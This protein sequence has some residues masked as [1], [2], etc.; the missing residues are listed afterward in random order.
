MSP[1]SSRGIQP[2]AA[3]SGY[4]KPNELRAV[5]RPARQRHHEAAWRIGNGASERKLRAMPSGA[6][7]ALRVRARSAA[8]G[9]HGLPCAS[10]LDQQQAACATRRQPVP[11][12]PCAD[13]R[14]RQ[15]HVHW[16]GGSLRLLA[17]GRLLERRLPRGDPRLEHQPEDVLLRTKEPMNSVATIGCGLL[18][19]VFIL[20]VQPQLHGAEVSAAKLPPPA[21]VTVDFG[22]D[23]KPIFEST[24]FRCHGPEKPKSRFRLDNRESALKGGE[25]NPDDIVP[26]ESGKSKLIH[27][28]ARLVEDMEMPPEGKGEPLTPEQIGMLRAWIDQGARWSPGSE[29]AVRETQFSIAPAVQWITVSGN[30]R[31]FREDWGTKEG[32]TAGYER[33]E[34]RQP[35]G[36]EAELR[37]EGRALF[38]QKDYRVALTLSQPDLGL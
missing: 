30:A 6:G 38:D 13:A 24:C 34:M 26:G 29:T 9:L 22:R 16:Q 31:K 5:P 3:S 15:P 11:E 35:V 8:R 32:F 7:A 12:M 21:G 4:R 14:R 37:V 36:K 10:R 28:V 33:F 17:F 27:Y 20:P 2:S 23:V 25:N 18:W 1:G 19:A